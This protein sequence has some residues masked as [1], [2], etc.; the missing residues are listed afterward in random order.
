M[1]NGILLLNKEKGMTSFD[2][3]KK[4]KRFLNVQ[5]LGHLG[6]LDPIG[7]GL[8]PIALG[9]ACK[10]FNEYL[11]KDKVYETVFEFG[12]TTDTLDNTGMVTKTDDKV[13]TEA[14]VKKVLQKLVGKQAQVPPAYSAK[15][16]NG[17]RAY[18]LARAGVEFEL[19]PKEIEIHNIELIDVIDKNLFAFRVE[20][21]GG[22][23]IRS[24]ARD[25]ATILGTYGRMNAIT[26]TRTG[27]FEL[28]DAF[29]LK[30]VETGNY[31]I[32]STN[33]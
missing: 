13:I 17:E 3:V 27:A 10:L 20:C 31:K 24:I 9:N 4:V 28:K 12:V 1:M 7:E 2:A 32:I 6:T 11:K 33:N 14:D 21:S 29:T 15:H 16:V 18:N 26:R 19:A 23:Y 30:D 5:K 25:L 22:T 8:L